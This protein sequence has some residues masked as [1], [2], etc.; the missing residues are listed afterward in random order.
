MKRP[1]QTHLPRPNTRRPHRTALTRGS[2]ILGAVLIAGTSALGQT[3]TRVSTSSS[4]IEGSGH[5]TQA[6]VSGDGRYVAFESNA[7]NLVPGQPALGHN[8]IYVK[9]SQ[10]GNIECVTPGA[11]LNCF[12]ASMSGDGQFLVFESSA[13]NLVLGDT[14]GFPDVFVHDRQ[15]GITELVS[16]TS[17]GNPG[18]DVSGYPSISSNGRHVAFESKS[19]NL[20]A[21]DTNGTFDVFVRDR[22]TGVTE[23]VSV[24]SYGNQAQGPSWEASISADGNWVAFTTFVALVSGDINSN[25]DV[26]IH[27]RSTQFTYIASVGIFGVPGNGASDSPSASGDGR[28]VAFV[29]DVQLVNGDA[30]NFDDIYVRDRNSSVTT[31]ASADPF[32][33]SGNAISSYPY[34]SGDGRYVAFESQASNLVANDTNGV[35]DVFIHSLETGLTYIVNPTY[36]NGPSRQPSVSHDGRY[37]AFDSDASNLVPNDLNDAI[38]AFLRDRLY[39]ETYTTYCNGGFS[40]SGCTCRLFASGVASASYTTGFTVTAQS[41]EGQKDGLFFYGQNGQ[42]MAPWG[43][44]TSFQCVVPPVKRGGTLSG[45]GTPGACDGLVAQDLNALWCPICP[46]PNHAPIPGR[47]LQIQFWYRDPLNT[48]NQSTSLSNAIEVDV[49]P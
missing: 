16:V 12:V 32:G 22:L 18:N 24:D 27:E 13:T 10:T 25:W 20:V 37:V 1:H 48:S 33:N 45:N 5:S 2:R 26:Y 14:N 17:S 34:L 39:T 8:L 7:G 29:T 15:T 47:P 30:N 44:G 9:D 49:S 4:G 31:L 42:Q 36:A 28:Y 40:A 35:S 11:D 46:K 41:L 23:L 6:S 19:S 21:S 43:N 3:T 38:D